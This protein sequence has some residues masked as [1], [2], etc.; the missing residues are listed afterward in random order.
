[1]WPVAS[2]GQSGEA[3]LDLHQAGDL[4]RVE[5]GLLCPREVS[6][7]S[8][9]REA[10]LIASAIWDDFVFDELDLH[11]TFFALN[12]IAPP[13]SS[14]GCAALLRKPVA[15]LSNPH[16]NNRPSSNYCRNRR[17]DRQTE[18]SPK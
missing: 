9:I 15:Q 8:A 4:L 17:D 11:Y 7:R 2:M 5:L 3:S 10:N 14:Q 6:G 12:L 1:M 13:A 16:H 18:E